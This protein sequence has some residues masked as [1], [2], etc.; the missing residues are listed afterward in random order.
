MDWVSLEEYFMS[1]DWKTE[2]LGW[3]FVAKD[4][5]DSIGY[6]SAKTSN[7][8]AGAM[9]ILNKSE[10]TISCGFGPSH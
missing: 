8:Y 7:K 3:A 1:N 5:S 10:S 6:I 4:G 2:S 9:C